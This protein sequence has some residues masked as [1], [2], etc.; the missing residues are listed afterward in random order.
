M[1][2]AAISAALAWAVLRA[3]SHPSSLIS[4]I[5]TFHSLRGWLIFKFGKVQPSTRRYP[6]WVERLNLRVFAQ[7]LSLDLLG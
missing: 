3:I 2:V 5:L 6:P 1:A 7:D 4:S